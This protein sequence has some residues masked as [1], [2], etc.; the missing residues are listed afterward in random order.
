MILCPGC[1]ASV[2]ALD[3]PTHAY[4]PSAPGCWK[5]F[6]EVQADE[7]TRFGYPDAHRLVVDAYMAQHPGDGHDRRD[8]QSV[9]FHLASI[10]ALTERSLPSSFASRLLGQLTKDRPAFPLLTRSSGP[11]ELNVLHMVGAADLDEYTSRARE[12]AAAVWDSWREQHDVICSAL[13]EAA[14]ALG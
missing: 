7:L 12:W 2:P 9:Y 10:C 14:S 3:G 5:T 4:V 1:S 8:R 6:G 11:G 13:D